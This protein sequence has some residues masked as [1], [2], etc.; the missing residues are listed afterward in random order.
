MVQNQGA[1]H[2][3]CYLKFNDVKLERAKKRGRDTASE[4]TNSGKKQ[5][6]RQSVDKMSVCFAIK[7]MDIS[8]SLEHLKPMIL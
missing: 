8:M 4:N 5:P 6:R 1:W 3:T 7:R 2:K